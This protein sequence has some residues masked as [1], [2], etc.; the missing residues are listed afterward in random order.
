[1]PEALES[2]IIA[3]EIENI[4]TM[5]GE[6]ILFVSPGIHLTEPVFIKL[7]EASV[8]GVRI[9]ILSGTVP[10]PAATRLL[11]VIKNLALICVENLNARCYF[12]ESRLIIT[13]MGLDD[14]VNSSAVN[15]GIMLKADSDLYNSIRREFEAVSGS[16]IKI[17]LEPGS[18]EHKISSDATYRGFC[19]GCGMPVTFNPARPYC[20]MCRNTFSSDSHDTPGNYCHS[21]GCE[22][23]V[24]ITQNICIK[25][26]AS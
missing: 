16:G 1:M 18:D 4:I 22:S 17:I 21:C 3:N 2:A 20:N 8:R 25:C 19:I 23:P 6:Y 5:S 26:S 13:S 12:N 7:A 9:T 24:T 15:T 14:M 10:D 11:S